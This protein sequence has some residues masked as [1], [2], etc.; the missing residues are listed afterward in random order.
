MPERQSPPGEATE[1]AVTPAPDPGTGDRG[2]AAGV[3]TPHASPGR[4][5]MP[6]RR[7]SPGPRSGDAAPDARPT[8][9][10]RPT[11]PA[12]SADARPAPSPRP[13]GNAEQVT[14]PSAAAGSSEQAAT[15]PAGPG[16]SSEQ[17]SATKQTTP[18][19]RSEQPHATRP[20]DP[21]GNGEQASAAGQ[22]VAVAG[23]GQSSATPPAPGGTAPASAPGGTS[24]GSASGGTAP[25]S[26]SGGAPASAPGGTAPASAPGA[27]APASAPG[28]TAP[29][30]APGGAAP[31]SEQ[32][33]HVLPRVPPV[34]AQGAGNPA[35]RTERIPAGGPAAFGGAAG[36]TGPGGPGGPGGPDGPGPDGGESGGDGGGEGGSGRKRP[37]GLIVAA[38]VLGVLVLA[39]V[40][41]LVLSSGSVPRGVTVA[42]QEIGGMSRAAATDKLKAAI[43]PRSSAPVQVQAGEVHSQIDPK[44]AGLQVDYRRTLDEAGEQPL[45]PITRVSSFFTQREVPVVDSADDRAVRTALEQM[46][47][48]VLR[49]PKEGSVEFQDLNPV[50]VAPKPGQT[51]DVDAAVGVVSQQW[52]TGRPVQLPLIVEQP[53]TTPAD[54]Q[55]AIDEVARPAV[56]APLTVT[57][58]GANATIEPE[59]IA[60]ALSFT[61]DPEGTAKLKPVIA[62]KILE[63]AA[64]PQLASTEKPGIDARLDFASTP[65]KVIPSQDG[66]GID[67]NATFA[68][69]LP[70]LTGPGPRQVP[71]VY[72]Q[73]PAEISTADLQSLGNAVEIGSFTTGGFAAD[74]GQNIKRAAEAIDGEIIQ[75]GETFSLNGV[76]NPRNLANGYVEAGVIEDGHPARGVGGGVSQL[77]TTLYNASYFAG[78]TD[79]E[80]K[81]HS[82]YISRYP[83]AREATVFNNLIDV[84]FR[85]DGPTAV[86]IK[87]SWTPRNVTVKFLGQKMYEVSSSTGPRTNP[88]EPQVVNIP[89]GQP[90]SPSKGSPGFTAT[91][92]RT[93]RNVQTGET[94]SETRTVKYNPQPIVHCGG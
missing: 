76:T 12:G 90:C 87:T 17:A 24:P 5:V 7:P 21:G 45:N 6:A 77:A 94:K 22:G 67:Y 72:A 30:S 3:D 73:K 27:T 20:V 92:T 74:S 23:A 50:P 65:P 1:H 56:S 57:G 86:L 70:V 37:T 33:T 54:V 85:N 28:A 9:S 26:A 42:G 64:K 82:Y 88:T 93:L 16:A 25:A 69:V 81:E 89:P 29:A 78:M 84:K 55:Q 40:G 41:D 63:E 36:A 13:T 31:L 39:Y 8:P 61:A 68:N 38:A 34:S 47:P 58:E 14:R 49:E 10:P 59:D 44:A 79:V 19:A 75:P 4:P 66:R 51:L 91:D 15:R 60:K 43:E 83:V 52:A 18:V 71:A 48:L 46:A 80:H 62:N 53:V 2:T 11:S 32:R 35:E